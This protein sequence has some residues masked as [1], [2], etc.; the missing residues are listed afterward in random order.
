MTC[1]TLLRSSND[2]AEARARALA[3]SVDPV[4]DGLLATVLDG[5]ANCEDFSGTVRE[6]FVEVV[7][8]VLRF[9]ADRVDAGR[10]SWKQD[11][12]YLFPPSPGDAPFGEE[13][14]QKDVYRWLGNSALRPYTRLEERD[15]AAGRADV[16][17]TRSHRFVIE[18]KRELSN[19]SRESLHVAYGG[20]AAAYSTG[21]P[22]ISLKM[23]LD[24]TN[25]TD[26]VASL[27]N[28]VWVDEVLAGGET[29]HVVMVV[30]RGNRPTPR[31]TKTGVAK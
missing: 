8:V 31:Q 7:T 25:H 17:V 16:S 24:P 28:S 29:C 2:Q 21:G 6:E 4:V 13:F 3:R 11:I 9:T 30:V 10:E 5:L 23:V 18:V 22:R 12:A 26:G 20:Q 27:A 14:L 19:A 15:V 1:P